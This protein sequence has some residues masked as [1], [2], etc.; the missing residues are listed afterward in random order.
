MLHHPQVRTDGTRMAALTQCSLSDCSAAPCSRLK[1]MLGKAASPVFRGESCGVR[2]PWRVPHA[3]KTARV[4]CIDQCGGLVFRQAPRAP[5]SSPTPAL[6]PR[7][8][9]GHRRRPAP[10]RWTHRR[11]SRSRTSPTAPPAPSRRAAPPSTRSWARRAAPRKPARSTLHPR[12]RCSCARRGRRPT[13]VSARTPNAPPRRPRAAGTRTAG[14]ATAPRG[15]T[16]R[17]MPSGRSRARPRRPLRRT[18]PTI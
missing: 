14:R 12:S 3:R 1:N 11:P 15:R 7:A 5:K 6:L 9:P 17:T 18:S 4:L 13:S 10:Q 8:H 2:Q 16:P